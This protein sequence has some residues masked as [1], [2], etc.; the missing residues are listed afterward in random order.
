MTL[1]NPYQLESEV[2]Q[3]LLKLDAGSLQCAYGII[4]LDVPESKKGNQHLVFK[5]HTA[6]QF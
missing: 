1:R 3:M 5:N 6:P 4:E 2:M